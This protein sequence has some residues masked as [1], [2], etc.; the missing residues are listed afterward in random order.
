MPR[1]A[2]A[3]EVRSKLFIAT[4]ELNLTDERDTLVMRKNT[5]T[6]PLRKK[7]TEDIIA[8]D[9]CMKE[10]N[11]V[12]RVLLRNGKRKRQ[13]FEDS[14]LPLPPP[15]PPRPP[16]QKRTDSGVGI[17]KDTTVLERSVKKI[18]LI[19]DTI[20]LDRSCQDSQ[21]SVE[22]ALP[23]VEGH[24]TPDQEAIPPDQPVSPRDCSS[25][26]TLTKELNLLR[27]DM[28]TIKRNFSS[29]Q[30]GVDN[31]NNSIISALH[32]D[33]QQ[34]KVDIRSLQKTGSCATATSPPSSVADLATPSQVT[35]FTRRPLT[36][37]SVT[38]W[39]CRGL[40]SATPYIQHLSLSS[41]INLVTSLFFQNTG[42]GHTSCL[43]STT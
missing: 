3:S 1:C 20:V 9:R 30:M 39:N 38:A 41:D 42:S 37:I 7:L 11:P 2:C 26:A 24:I 29:L 27:K 13:R 17:M 8:L 19:K 32:T 5:V 28:D 25:L 4:K 14:R 15:T 21:L 23:C 6:N 12:P 40:T 43:S 34:M 22:P 36:T 31:N 35:P 18:K 16:T 10:G 33:L